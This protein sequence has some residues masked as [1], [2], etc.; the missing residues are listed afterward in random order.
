MNIK[1][2]THT[3][4]D[5]MADKSVGTQSLKMDDGVKKFRGKKLRI[6][7][8]GCGG[9]CQ[10]HMEAYQEI[11]QVEV[12]ACCDIKPEMLTR[13]KEKWGVEKGYTDWKDMLKKEKLDAVDVCTPNGVHMQPV[14][15][16][17]NKGLHAMVEKP[18]AMNA[19][20]CEKMIAAAK[21]NN[22]KLAVGFQNRY[23]DNTEFLV[24]ARDKGTFGDIMF[25]KCRALRR[26][27]IPNW[28]VFGQK[29]LQGG[30]PMIDIGVHTLE[31]AHFFMGEPK[32][33]AASGNIWTYFGNKKSATVCPWPNWDYKTYNVE[34]LAIGQIRFEN[35]AILQIEA[36]FVANIENDVFTWEV[37]GTKAGASWIPPKIYQDMAGTMVNIY[38]NYI[39]EPTWTKN[40]VRKLENWVN[41]CL[42]GPPLMASGESGLA[43]QKMLDGVYRSAEAGREVTID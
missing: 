1:T 31:S 35:G 5:K 33:V 8:I 40:F 20:E 29:E 13:M 17:C 21:K 43:V 42:K 26:R 37:M 6:G 12:V 2:K 41:A 24:R 16:A 28:G 18:M 4:A 3:G 15:D 23:H 10:T 30:G 39:P 11:P 19:G 22:V 9:I 32:P 34:D 27:G 36:S 25:V 7:M 38:P 14:I